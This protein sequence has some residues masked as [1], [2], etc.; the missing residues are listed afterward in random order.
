[1]ENQTEN[2]VSIADLFNNIS[3][4]IENASGEKLTG[5]M[6]L[7]ATASLHSLANAANQLVSIQQENEVLK[8]Q[9]KNAETTNAAL[10]AKIDELE[11]I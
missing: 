6:V 2:K 9:I 10:Q 4:L 5:K 8:E 11:K 7:S 1:M 3:T